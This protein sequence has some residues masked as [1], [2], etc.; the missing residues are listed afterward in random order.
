MSIKQQVLSAI[1]RLPDDINF[2]DITEE[3]ALLAALEEG[4]EDIR[5]GRTVSNDQMKGRIEQ[6]LAH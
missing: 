3:I 6:W 2:R 1:Q 4:E 5:E